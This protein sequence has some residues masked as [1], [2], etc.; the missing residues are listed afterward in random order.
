MLVGGLAACVR[1]G[2]AL[3]VPCEQLLVEAARL[4]EQAETRL[5]DDCGGYLDSAAGEA[6]LFV[7]PRTA[8][9]GT[10]PTGQSAMLTAL[11]DL[12]ELTGDVVWAGRAISMLEGMSGRLAARSMASLHALRALLRVFDSADLRER[13]GAFGPE[14]QQQSPV[15]ADPPDFTPVEVYADR[16][17]IQVG[18]GSPA[19][20][21]LELRIAPGFHVVAADPGASDMSESLVPMRVFLLE[22]SGIEVYADYPDGKPWGSDGIL[23]HHDTVRVRV[24]VERTEKHPERALLGVRFQAC[25]ERSCRI[26]TTVELDLSVEML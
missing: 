26:P 2:R 13:A 25:D 6:E 4:A 12:S 8:Y 9:D 22:G 18:P 3:S 7:S 24:A 15:E 23:V 19:E 20:L 5:K 17:S 1:A 16:E 11:L 21:W 14:A 10:M